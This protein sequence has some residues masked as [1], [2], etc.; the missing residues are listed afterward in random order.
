M[1]WMA[2]KDDIEEA[3]PQEGAEDAI[4]KAEVLSNGHGSY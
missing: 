1:E 3:L 4:L 2:R